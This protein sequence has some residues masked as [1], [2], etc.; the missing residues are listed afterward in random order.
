[1]GQSDIGIRC[2]HYANF[3]GI[4]L[5]WCRQWILFHKRKVSYS[6]IH[7]VTSFSK[8]QFFFADWHLLQHEKD[9]WSMFSPLSTWIATHH[10]QLWFSTLF[11][12]VRNKPRLLL[13]DQ[14]LTLL[15]FSLCSNSGYSGKHWKSNWLFQLYR[16]AFLRCHNVGV[17]HSSLQI[18]LQRKTTAIQG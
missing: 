11:S 16:M 3:G 2:Y 9:I 14:Q 17:D 6:H 12:R 4:V 8:H 15:C 18:S 13:L 7:S 10:R 1:M 5:V